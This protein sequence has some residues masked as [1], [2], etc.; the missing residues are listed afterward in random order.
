MYVDVFFNA[1]IPTANSLQPTATPT[2][3]NTQLTTTTKH[4]TQHHVPLLP[5]AL[6]WLQF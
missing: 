1:L 3:K 6:Q 4:K 5:T 2:P